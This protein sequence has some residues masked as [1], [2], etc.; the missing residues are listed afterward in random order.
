M[1]VD[2]VSAEPEYVKL[3]ESKK[4]TLE[5]SAKRRGELLETRKT[6]NESIMEF[7]AYLAHQHALAQDAR[8]QAAFVTFPYPP[9]VAPLASLQRILQRE[10][11][12]EV[13]HRGRYMLLRVVTAPCQLSLNGVM[14][15]VEDEDGDLNL[16]AAY[17]Q[18]RV[19]ERNMQGPMCLRSVCIVKE[20]FFRISGDG[21]YVISVIHLSD[22]FWLAIDDERI[23]PAWRVESGEP[24]KSADERK[25]A[26]DRA[27]RLGCYHLAV[28]QFVGT[29]L[30]SCSLAHVWSDTPW[31]L[32]SRPRPRNV[33]RFGS[34]ELGSF[35]RWG[36]LTRPCATPWQLGRMSRKCRCPEQ[37][38]TPWP[39]WRTSLNDFKRPNTTSSRSCKSLLIAE[40]SGWR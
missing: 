11:Q 17:H 28:N 14:T 29:S 21:K 40:G 23:P 33:R 4:A 5:A 38:W 18:E 20:P 12:L 36:V 24:S 10:L 32:D 2:D 7:M 25:R 22:L 35:S 13:R 1:D 16:L 3:L 30:P 31:H 19:S 9:C 8:L 6:R 39:R 15:V 34:V 27:F 37:P 26:G